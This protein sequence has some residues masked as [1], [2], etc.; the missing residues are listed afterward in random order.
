M[1]ISFAQ[2]QAQ[3]LA[4][5]FLDSIGQTPQQVG[6]E[7]VEL[8]NVAKTV[9]KASAQFAA[10]AKLNLQ[11]R[12]QVS[13]GTLSDSIKPEV[14]E[15][16]ANNIVDIYVADYYKFLDKGVK[17]YTGQGSGPYQ[18]KN[19]FVGRK[20]VNEIQKWLKRE[21]LGAR[22]VKVAVSSREN[23]RM[24]IGDGSSSR[25][26]AFAVARA[27]KKKGIKGS[28]FW[29]DA[30][31]TLEEQFANEVANALRIDVIEQIVPE[32]L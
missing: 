20:M 26:T 15:L 11:Q 5:D 19:P 30:V 13:S 27:I 28:K 2:A 24:Q 9:I 12:D 18:F 3:L 16:G 23:R 4:T 8:N 7:T 6:G 29:T 32:E 22:N 31:K 21:G 17:G 14:V 25:S 10:A 1:A